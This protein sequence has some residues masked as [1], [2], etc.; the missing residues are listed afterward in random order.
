MWTSKYFQAP[1]LERALTF[2]GSMIDDVLPK[3]E[4]HLHLDCS[5]SYEG[6]RRLRPSVTL[7]EY[8]REYEAPTRC[9]NLAEFL[10]RVPKVLGML[11]SREALA[12]MVEDVFDQLR[13]DRVLYAELRFA[14]L[15]H[16]TRGLSAEGT[17][18]TVA[19]AVDE[20][21]RRTGIEARI[22]LC[23]VRHFTADESLTTA[24]LVRA[25][26]HR[27]VV[28][29]DIAGDEAGFA[30]TPHAAAYRYA[31][32]HGLRTTAHAGEALGPA[33]V[34]E[35]LRELAPERIGHGIRSIEDPVLIDHLRRTGVHLEVCPSSNMQL[36][37]SIGS[38]PAHPIDRLRL[39]GI[40]LN[41]NTD[42]RMLTPTTLTR[43]Y[44]LVRE[45]FG[46]TSDL[47][48]ASNVA[49]LR[50]AFVDEETRAGLLSELQRTWSR[51]ID[52]SQNMA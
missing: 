5:L 13:A 6:V 34:W 27:R 22:I 25:F 33:S 38:W 29:L 44:A 20:M 37:E 11:Q 35:T 23:T 36:V 7:D 47:L 43:E 32:E 21:V 18:D 10:S 16:T 9:A 12:I 51:A 30:L 46:W 8:R 28:A 49:A 15:L 41:V 39:A 24:E 14:P 26:R 40:S 42:T 1:P 48:L 31:H 45:H 17:V 52:G 50:K 19:T 3:I 2:N 4:L